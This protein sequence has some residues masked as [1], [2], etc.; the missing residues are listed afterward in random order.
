MDRTFAE[1]VVLVIEDDRQL[2]LAMT[3]VFTRA[4]ARVVMAANGAEGLRY[5]MAE[6][7]DVVVTD[8]IMPEREGIETIL[9]MKAAR[10]EAPILAVSGG[11]QTPP[12]QFLTLAKALGADA[13]LAKP[14]RA[15]QLLDATRQ[16]INLS[17]T[18]VAA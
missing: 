17:P 13:V 9:A 5:F 8:I 7:P 6:S 3:E 2:L 14:F 15:Q 1:R 12:R 16:L 10:P 4:G 11:G 18:D